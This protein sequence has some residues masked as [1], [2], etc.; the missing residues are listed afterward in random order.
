MDISIEATQDF[1]ADLRQYHEPERTT[2]GEAINHCAEWMTNAGNQSYPQLKQLSVILPNGYESTLHALQVSTD[3]SMIL[4]IDADPI[5]GKT[6]LTLFRIIPKQTVEV[7]Y[8]AIAATL[9]QDLYSG[10]LA[11]AQAS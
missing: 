9:Y 8:R 3:L 1:E 2:I 6:I 10:D 11:I 5:F 7:A 4:T